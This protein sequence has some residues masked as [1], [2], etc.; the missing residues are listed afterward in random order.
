VNKV[1]VEDCN[2]CRW[3]KTYVGTAVRGIRSARIHFRECRFTHVHREAL[4]AS[5]AHNELNKVW[6]DEIPPPLVATLILDSIH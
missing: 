2:H 6:I 5:L 3:S 4:L 1:S